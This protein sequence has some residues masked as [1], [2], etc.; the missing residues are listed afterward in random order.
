MSNYLDLW[1][2]STTVFKRFDLSFKNNIIVRVYIIY[3]NIDYFYNTLLSYVWKLISKHTY[4]Q[5][6]I[7]SNFDRKCKLAQ[8]QATFQNYS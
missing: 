8:L 6:L 5:H 7:K 2:L 4:N 3:Y 1:C